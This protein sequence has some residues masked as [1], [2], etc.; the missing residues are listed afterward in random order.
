MNKRRFD[1][2]V[3]K[4]VKYNRLDMHGFDQIMDEAAEACGTDEEWEKFCSAVDEGSKVPLTERE[5]KMMDSRKKKEELEQAKMAA[6]HAKRYY[7]SL[8]GKK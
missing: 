4:A 2:L 3:R 1:A 8:L 7:E 5:Q 6:E